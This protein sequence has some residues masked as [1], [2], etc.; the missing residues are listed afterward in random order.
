LE[1]EQPDLALVVS[2]WSTLSDP[3]RAAVLA[4]VSVGTGSATGSRT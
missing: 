1:R 2:S 3:L 4:L